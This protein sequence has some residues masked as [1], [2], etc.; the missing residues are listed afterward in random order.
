M[1][2]G[3]FV[4][5]GRK[6][7]VNHLVGEAGELGDGVGDHL[8]RGAAIL[9][10]QLEVMTSQQQVLAAI[11]SVLGKEHAISVKDVVAALSAKTGLDLS[12]YAAAWI[13]GTGAPEWPV[14]NTTF[15][16]GTGTS[17]LRVTQT[18]G[19][20]RRCKFHVALEGAQPTEVQLVGV[21]T[22]KNGIDQTMVEGAS[23]LDENPDADPYPERLLEVR[24]AAKQRRPLPEPLLLRPGESVTARALR[25][26]TKP[27][28]VIVPTD[29]RRNTFP[30]SAAAMRGARSFIVI[31][32]GLS[33]LG[34]VVSPIAA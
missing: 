22:F 18:K 13:E 15:T 33:R 30:V 19:Q 10:R 31:R 29:E 14:I 11:A 16:A 34:S 4:G 7:L 9:F 20:A 27:P 5:H 25:Q 21:D 3:I 2:S 28:T 12:A 17:T 8:L 24:H 32:N 26:T 6:E 23:T 1:L